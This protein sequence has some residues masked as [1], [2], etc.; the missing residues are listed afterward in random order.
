M[1]LLWTKELSWS[2]ENLGGTCVYK[3]TRRRKRKAV[4]EPGNGSDALQKR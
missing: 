1:S 4:W 3:K 2:K